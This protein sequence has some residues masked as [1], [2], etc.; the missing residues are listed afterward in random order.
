MEKCASF[1]LKYRKYKNNEPVLQFRFYI[2][3]G[4]PD[5]EGEWSKWKNVPI[6]VTDLEFEDEDEEEMGMKH[7]NQELSDHLRRFGQKEK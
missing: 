3:D 4:Q 7:T 1:E 6:I 2:G 5:K